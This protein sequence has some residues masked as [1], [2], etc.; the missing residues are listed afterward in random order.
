MQQMAQNNVVAAFLSGLL[1]T[2]GASFS[3]MTHPSKVLGFL[4]VAGAWDPSLAFVMA[5]ALLV[6]MPLF[7]LLKRQTKPLF[8]ASFHFPE[9]NRV[10]S[11]LI[12][13]A[14]IFGIGWGMAGFCPGPALASI[15]TFSQPTILFFVSMLI[16]MR[17]CQIIKKRSAL[18]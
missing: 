4:D 10:D 7:H 17:I 5:G 9:A 15:V 2:I 16:G 3:G 18:P 11:R 8:G 1:F 12:C 14:L 6:Y 13:G